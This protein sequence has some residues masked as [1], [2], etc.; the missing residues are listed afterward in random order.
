VPGARP[1]PPPH[2][3]IVGAGFGGLNAAK[4]LGKA[5]VR[6]TLL[7]RRNHHVFQPLLYQVA[8]AGLSPGEI[9]YPIRAIVRRQ[10]NTEVWLA[11]AT[12]VDLDRRR[13]VLADGVIE[14][15][16]LILAAG[17]RHSY[18]AHPEWESL[19][20]GLKDVEDALDIRRRILL[21]F[22]RAERE[23]DPARR[24][25]QLTFAI[26]GGGPTG[27]ELA[28]AIADIARR[29][30]VKDFRVIDPREARILLLE[31]GPR[32]L[33][34]FPPRLSAKAETMLQQLGVEVRTNALVTA[35]SADSLAVGS[36]ALSA[37]TILWAAGVT[38]SPLARS[39]GVPLDHAGRVPV[40]PD[41]SLPGHPEVFAIG[42]LATLRDA[43]GQFL[44]GLAP[45][46]IQQGHAAADNLLRSLRGEP[47][48]DF[49]YLDKGNLATIGR[50]RA[51]ADIRGLQLS[52]WPAWLVWV[53]VH[54]LYLIGFRNRLLVATEWSWD[55][56][57]FQQAARLI[58]GRIHWTAKGGA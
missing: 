43:H 52:G 17:A 21:A 22:E 53:F 58:T 11:E 28:G 2:V 50:A 30:L 16:Y 35:L 3:V 44:P 56:L 14:Y 19:A 33:P 8:T 29:V 37:A 38:A 39:L 10:A 5:P 40:Q 24:Q 31:G 55:Y 15:E 25:S 32:L 27:V 20:P 7:D 6:V 23:P 13:V 42:D 4:A 51:V 45:V 49:H 47:P 57:S 54:I 41:L 46:A 34:A 36:E 1:A 9:A 48:R 18:F 26:V 12:A